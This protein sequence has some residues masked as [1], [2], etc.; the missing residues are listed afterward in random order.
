M[1]EPKRQGIGCLSM[2]LLWTLIIIIAASKSNSHQE[3]ID[4]FPAIPILIVFIIIGIIIEVLISKNAESSPMAS[5]LIDL[6]NKQLQ[7]DRKYSSYFKSVNYVGGHEAYSDVVIGNL[8]I[9]DVNLVFFFDDKFSEGEWSVKTKNILFNIPLNKIDNLVYDTSENITLSRFLLIGLASF[10][11]KKKT[12]YLIIN[13]K[14]ESNV[15]NQVIFETGTKKNQEFF[16]QL[17]IARNKV[18]NEILII[19]RSNANNLITEQIKELSKLKDDGI[20]TEEEFNNK[21]K[22]LL[23]RL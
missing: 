2:F 6:E 17:N 16:N 20:V 21:K 1:A 3:F 12:C 14:S 19:E 18:S 5:K 15:G 4:N 8:G 9:T 13:Y 11:F 22:E 7:D 23:S 10:V